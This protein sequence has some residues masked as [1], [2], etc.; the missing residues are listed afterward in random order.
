VT[1]ER[2]SQIEALFHAVCDA[3]AEQRAGL[4]AQADPEVR[5]EV[6]S[7][8]AARG[9]E[10]LDRPAIHCAPY[11]LEELTATQVS[12]GA[13]LGPY[14]IESKLGEG[15]MGEVFRAV[16]T[17]LGRAVA[18][19]TVHERFN[20]RF[21]RE[22]R[23]IS[24]LNH[25]N[26]CTLHDIGPNYLVMEL[27]EG[28][29]LA[30]RLKHGAM[31]LEMVRHYGVQIASALAEA[32]AKGIIHRDLKPGNIMIARS[33]I[34]V[35]DFGLAKS[36]QDETVTASRMILGT[37]AYMSPEQ[38]EGNPADARSDIYAFGCVLYEMSTGARAGSERKRVGS[39]KLER[40]ISRCLEEAPEKRWQSV[41]EIERE[42]A[43]VSPAAILWKQI[44]PAGVLVVALSA[45]AYFYIHRLPKLTGKDTIVLADFDNKTGDEVFYG[46]LRQGLAVQLEQSPFLSLISDERVQKVLGLMGQRPNARLTPQLA[47]EVCERTA[48]AA[49][50]DG[51]IAKL[52]NKYVLGIRAR[53]CTTGDVLDEEQVQA[54]GKEDVLR[55]LSEIA[56]KFRIRVG[57]SL[58]TVQKHS[59][60]LAEATTPSLEALKAYSSAQSVEDSAGLAAGVDVLNRAIEIDPQ[61]ALAYARRGLWQNNLGESALSKESAVKAYELR[62]RV[63]DR[64]QFFIT[65]NYHRQ[66]TGNLEKAQQTLELWAQIYPREITPHGL[67][68]GFVCQSPGKYEKATEEAEK[69]I[70]I[71]PDF[72]PPYVNLAFSY[73]YL[74]RLRDAESTIHRASD[75]KLEIPTLWV[76]RYYI[77]FLNGDKAGMD[78][79]V[80]RAKG[81][82]GVEDH[83]A[84]SEALVAARSGRLEL[85]RRMSRHAVDVAQ[86]AGQRERAALYK[87]GTAVWEAFFGNAPAARRSATAA[88]AI[89]HARDVEYGAA[90]ALALVGDLARSQ[91]LAEDLQEHFPED[92]SVRFHYLPTLHG[93]LALHHG[94]PAD[95]IEILQPAV[96]VERATPAISFFA[97]FGSLYSAYVRGEAFLAGGRGA[98]AATEFQKIIDHRGLV[99]ADPVGAMAR[100]GLG[101]ALVLSGNHDKAKAV[102]Q[103][104][105]TLWKDADPDISIV[106]Q[107]NAE[108]ARLQ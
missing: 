60:P 44:V 10:I 102:Y 94:K 84:Y 51:S 17:R 106:R 107:A 25:P 89:S 78:Q 42:L 98:E 8:L 9:G 37:P 48:S 27:I 59:T 80:V 97:Y 40:I 104:L 65:A 19:K 45:S 82:A 20:A 99:L 31:S 36:D 79:E 26:I 24:S 54:A 87:A 21:E 85:A 13:Q 15:G 64:E 100:L 41:V 69:A 39:A 4:L 63:S 101:K 103:D 83:L 95:A 11:L 86:Q 14:R 74:D 88:L 81:K 92:T 71:D 62:T 7:L 29:T 68:S 22:A 90:F 105:L 108:Y 77:A 28:E 91:A 67:M 5:R 16:D 66:V 43:S 96:P 93:L 70:A 1:P 76:V 47:R 33:G 57:E 2:A 49:V 55:A 56:N 75:R 72:P 30:S 52:G 3:T 58:A 23:A 61:F 46:T 73:V 32:H 53:N 35:L 50:L 6:D 12:A 38:K 34:K 18:I